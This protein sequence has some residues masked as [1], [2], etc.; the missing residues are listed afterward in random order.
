LSVDTRG[1]RRA[2][3]EDADAP[4]ASGRLAGLLA[5]VEVLA[6]DDQDA[7]RETVPPLEAGVLDGTPF[8]LVIVTPPPRLEGLSDVADVAFRLTRN[9]LPDRY[10]C[11][12]RG[13]AFD[14]TL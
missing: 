13:T 10:E 12:A 5:D 9:R 4:T 1:R 6:E 3:T 8:G 11:R 7:G 2:A 14:Q